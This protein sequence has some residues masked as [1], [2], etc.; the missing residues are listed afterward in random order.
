MIDPPI[1]N[2]EQPYMFTVRGQD[3]V[4]MRVLAPDEVLITNP[5]EGISPIIFFI[6]PKAATIK[7]RLMA[8]LFQM[9][10]PRMSKQDDD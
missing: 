3:S 6:A 1:D 7:N 10:G 4:D 2:D 8:K 9:L 5:T